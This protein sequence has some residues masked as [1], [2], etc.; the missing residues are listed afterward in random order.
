MQQDLSACAECRR[1]KA[2]QEG[3]RGGRT[4]A[5]RLWGFDG[6][7]AWVGMG[8]PA[9]SAA[10]RGPWRRDWR[11]AGG[12]Q[13]ELG[14]IGRR[15]CIVGDGGA[16]A[17]RCRKQD[18]PAGG[19]CVKAMTGVMA[20]RPEP[21]LGRWRG[22]PPR[23]K[24]LDDDH[25]AAATSLPVFPLGQSRQYEPGGRTGTPGICCMRRPLTGRRSRRAGSAAR[26]PHR[27][28]ERAGR[29]RRVR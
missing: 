20:S 25:A 5:C 19:S 21:G 27:A 4:T 3:T 11:H 6:A 28:W 13:N 14:V 24:G 22:A 18:A 17:T 26:V 10:D 2:S 8:W 9:Y 23:S 15:G 16:T 29:F 7:A 1:P 12:R